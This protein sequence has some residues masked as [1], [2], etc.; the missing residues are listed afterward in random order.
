MIE[1]LIFLAA[2]I[3]ACVLLAGILGYFGNHILSRGIIFIDIA[4]AQIV[5]L[6]TNGSIPP[7]IDEPNEVLSYGDVLL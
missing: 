1:N 5:A 3:T 4:L 2:P 7:S 6:G